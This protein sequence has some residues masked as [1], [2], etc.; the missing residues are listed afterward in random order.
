MSSLLFFCGVSIIRRFC[1]HTLHVVFVYNSIISDPVLA[2]EHDGTGKLWRSCFYAPIGVWRKKLS[3][4][5][6]KQGPNLKALEQAFRKFLGEAMALYEYLV[7]QY[8]SK[9]VPGSSQENSQD[10]SQG[11]TTVATF[12][13]AHHLESTEGVVPG[14]CT[15]ICSIR[16]IHVFR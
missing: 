7:I 3:R 12:D 15:Y 14:L 4:E 10:I 6:R 11:S 13:S 2:L 1:T 16:S 8:Q 9:L 5:K